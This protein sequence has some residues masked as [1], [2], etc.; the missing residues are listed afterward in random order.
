MTPSF[1][2][3]SL[4]G[5]RTSVGTATLF[6]TRVDGAHWAVE[7]EDVEQLLANDFRQGNIISSFEVLTGVSVRRDWLE[8]LMPG[9]H[10]SAANPFHDAHVVVLDRTL[11]RIAASE[12]NLVVIS[13]SY[14][15][16]FLAL[17]G[18][19]KIAPA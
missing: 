2:D 17:C 4:T 10:P 9:P 14:G 8:E 19:V 6:I 7:L 1:H 16:D 18:R 5:I 13:P 12:L 15:C 3:G 11:S